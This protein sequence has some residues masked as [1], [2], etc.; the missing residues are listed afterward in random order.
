MPRQS[1]LIFQPFTCVRQS[2]KTWIAKWVISIF[3]TFSKVLRSEDSVPQ[4]ISNSTKIST[5]FFLVDIGYCISTTINS[6]KH[7]YYPLCQ[8]CFPAM[9]HR[10][11]VDLAPW[12]DHHYHYIID[13]EWYLSLQL[14]ILSSSAWY[15]CRNSYSACMDKG[16]RGP[17]R[18]QSLSQQLQNE[19]RIPPGQLYSRD[20][21]C[22]LQ[23]RHRKGR[24][25]TGH[26]F[27]FCS[28]TS[29]GR[30]D[31]CRHLYCDDGNSRM[32]CYSTFTP[33]MDGTP[34]GTNKVRKGTGYYNWIVMQSDQ[35]WHPQLR[36]IYLCSSLERVSLL[37]TWWL[38]WCVAVV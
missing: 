17:S 33:A 29:Y 3:D 32:G 24:Y 8:T 16:D 22:R 14:I 30:R 4:E 9:P 6:L 31:I 35:T 34:C 15:G 7:I 25:P 36:P 26:S 12:R 19:C 23:F 13:Y 27:K 18:V 37:C 5:S 1:L 11:E 20:E 38:L 2:L 10:V 28:R 21:Q